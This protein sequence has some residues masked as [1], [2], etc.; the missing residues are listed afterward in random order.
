MARTNELSGFQIVLSEG[1]SEVSTY[2]LPSAELVPL[3]V[4][5]TFQDAKEA[6]EAVV[7]KLPKFYPVAYGQAF[8]YE[9]LSFGKLLYEKGFAAYGWFTLEDEELGESVRICIGMVRVGLVL[10]AA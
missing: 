1:A 9:N 2:S 10:P 5:A 7:A 3:K 8:P 4:Y 6:L